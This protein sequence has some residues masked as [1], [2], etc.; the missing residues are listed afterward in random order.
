M[1][2]LVEV[3]LGRN[4]QLAQLVR[5]KGVAV[6]VG[7]QAMHVRAG[8]GAAHCGIQRQRAVAAGH[9]DRTLGQRADLFQLHSH[10]PQIGDDSV[11]RGVVD[12][13]TGRGLGHQEFVQVEVLGEFDV[14]AGLAYMA[15]S[16]RRLPR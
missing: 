10:T 5:R 3:D 11:A 12:P 6:N 14:H 4:Q 1:D 9:D 13:T 15:S 7:S 8:L 16:M 2:Q